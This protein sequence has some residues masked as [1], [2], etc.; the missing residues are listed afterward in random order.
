MVNIVPR[1]LH[2][3]TSLAHQ[4]S[5]SNGATDTDSK[6]REQTQSEAASGVWNKT[7]SSC[8]FFQ[9][10]LPQP[11]AVEPKNWWAL[12][13]GQELLP[14]AINTLQKFKPGSASAFSLLPTTWRPLVSPL[15]QP[16]PRSWLNPMSALTSSRGVYY[17]L[18]QPSSFYPDLFFAFGLLKE[19]LLT[20]GGITLKCKTH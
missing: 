8:S 17:F 9:T 2:I 6:R 14:F 7:Q 13:W 5:P 10:T 4:P 20:M 12:D 19:Y 18:I 1:D 11:A 15:R 3:F 16:L